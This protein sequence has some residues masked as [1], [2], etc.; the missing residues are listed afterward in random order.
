MVSQEYKNTKII[1]IHSVVME[2]GE[3]KDSRREGGQEKS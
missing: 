2:D 3:R 1:V